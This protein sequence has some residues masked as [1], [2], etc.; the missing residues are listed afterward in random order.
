MTYSV[1]KVPLNPNQ[2]TEADTLTIRLGATQSGLTTAHLHHSPLFLQARCP[3]C[4]P[5]VSKHWREL[6]Q[7]L[8]WSESGEPV[9][10]THSLVFV[11][12]VMFCLVL[13]G[14][15]ES[16]EVVLLRTDAIPDTKPGLSKKPHVGQFEEMLARYNVV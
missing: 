7:G 11:C 15:K 2:P 4:R 3:S 14:Y 1:L 10:D 12:N 9:S 8:T 16:C 6:W 5:T 13:D